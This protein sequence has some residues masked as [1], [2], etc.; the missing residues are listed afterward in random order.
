[1]EPHTRKA[2]MPELFEINSKYLNN[3]RRNM[4]ISSVIDHIAVTAID[5][6]KPD[7]HIMTPLYQ[8]ID[9]ALEY[10]RLLSANDNDPDEEHEREQ[11]K[12]FRSDYDLMSLLIRDPEI[13][14][15]ENLKRAGIAIRK[16]RKLILNPPKEDKEKFIGLMLDYAEM[17]NKSR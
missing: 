15:R 12:S 10:I 13:R 16:F 5:N 8:T 1:M 4:Y 2:F 3:T 6:K 11:L 14:D 7:L 9:N 17:L